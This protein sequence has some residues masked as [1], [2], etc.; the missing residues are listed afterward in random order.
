MRE[1][2]RKVDGDKVEVTEGGEMERGD[3]C[4]RSTCFFF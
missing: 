4:G 3:K 2:E 1:G